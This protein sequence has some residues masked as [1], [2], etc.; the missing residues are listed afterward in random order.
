MA[1]TLS[2]FLLL[3]ISTIA[4]SFATV[5]QS[6]D[7][8]PQAGSVLYWVGHDGSTSYRYEEAVLFHDD[9]VTLYQTFPEEYDEDRGPTVDDFYILLS[10]VQHVACNRELPSA[11]YRE[12][13]K[14]YV[15]K[16][17]EGDEFE[18]VGDHRSTLQI[19]AEEPVFLM[20]ET[21]T[22]TWVHADTT[23]EQYL[24]DRE[25]GLNFKLR[26][27]EDI[28][29]TLVLKTK[30]KEIDFSGIMVHLG[31]CAMLISE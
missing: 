25:S 3:A 16:G 15:R 13:L 7:L 30:Q 23:D 27:A 28:S 20:G 21:F 6:S 12:R 29:D 26:W 1:N 5:A 18:L 8:I 22:G 2:R 4:G 9:D 10:G 14:A 24:I 19:K 31:N 11:D 17:A